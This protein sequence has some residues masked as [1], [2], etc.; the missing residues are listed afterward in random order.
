MKLFHYKSNPLIYA[1]IACTMAAVFISDFYIPLGVAVW[2]FFMIPVV[3][4]I[5]L[6]RP[7]IPLWIALLA[8]GIIILGYFLSS[9]GVNPQLARLNR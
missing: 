9:P 6:W 7:S 8:T 3:L 4:S 1:L 2:V 5:L